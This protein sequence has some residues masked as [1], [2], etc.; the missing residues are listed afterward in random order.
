MDVH[1]WVDPCGWRCNKYSGKLLSCG[2]EGE[3]SRVRP[4]SPVTNAALTHSS[5]SIPFWL[6]RRMLV[7]NAISASVGVI[8]FIGDVVLAL[9]K[10]NSRNAALLEEFLRIRGE[11]YLKLASE[12]RDPEKIAAEAKAEIKTGKG[13]K[14]E[15]TVKKGESAKGKEKEKEKE[16]TLE[17]APGIT[18]GDVGRVQPGAG[19]KSGEVIAGVTPGE[20]QTI[21]NKSSSPR[22][23]PS[24]VSSKATKTNTGRRLSFG[25]FGKKARSTQSKF[26]ENVEPPSSDATK[27]NKGTTQ[28]TD[29]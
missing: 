25:P 28:G 26:V 8:P 17:V 4:T 16:K 21:A 22:E 18:K 7:N 23:V 20:T 19:K 1:P 24:D 5:F 12:G 10:A 14:D 2:E 29:A 9:Y 11:V 3:T 13:K 15:T 27:N 6:L